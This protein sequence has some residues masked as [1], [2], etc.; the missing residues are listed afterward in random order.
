M[1]ADSETILRFARTIAEPGERALLINE[2]NEPGGWMPIDDAVRS[3]RAF[4]VR[5]RPKILALDADDP[6]KGALLEHCAVC[7]ARLAS[8]SPVLVAS[9]RLGHRHLFVRIIDAGIRTALE[10]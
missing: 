1:P 9:G 4:A 6:E 8:L 7:M 10:E 2:K 3:G 5:C